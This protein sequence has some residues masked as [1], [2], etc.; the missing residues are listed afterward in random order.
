MAMTRSN[1]TTSRLLPSLLGCMLLTFFTCSPKLNA[2]ES[3]SPVLVTGEEIPSAYGAPP[4]FSRTRSS[5]L[6]T[7]YVLPPWAFFFGTIYQGNFTKEGPPDHIFTQEVEMGL[8]YRFGLA[9]EVGAER[10][11]GGSGVQNIS[12]EGRYALADWNKIPLNP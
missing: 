12:V 3:V 1:L 5:P 4:A 11:D 7:A 2:Q 8:P 6:T 10:F 9:S